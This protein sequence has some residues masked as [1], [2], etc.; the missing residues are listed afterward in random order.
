MW[1]NL[2]EV[3][4][5]GDFWYDLFD[6]P[7]IKYLILCISILT[8]VCLVPMYHFIFLH[9]QDKRYRTVLT[10]G[11]NIVFLYAYFYLC[12]P[13]ALYVIRI[14]SGPMPDTLCWLIIFFMNFG[15]FGCQ[16]GLVICIIVRYLYVIVYKSVGIFH[17][18]F[19]GCFLHLLTF[20]FCLVAAFIKVYVP[21]KMGLNYYICTGENPEPYNYLGK[22]VLT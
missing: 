15:I 10:Y 1:C 7:Y 8:L 9:I 4:F 13:F 22:K 19:F 3:F 16:F 12:V 2:D 14:F 18:D 17:D 5:A 6:A 11:E 21:G 20:I